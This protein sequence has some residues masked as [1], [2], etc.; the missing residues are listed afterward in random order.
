LLLKQW[1]WERLYV[2]IKV[3]TDD[4][5]NKLIDIVTN[6]REM[7]GNGEIK[8]YKFH[9]DE[10]TNTLDITVTPVKSLQYL[11]VDFTITPTG[12]EFNK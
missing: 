6:I 10:E 8:D 5:A 7:V 12:A 11:K 4:K 1:Y 3:M 9:F 2:K